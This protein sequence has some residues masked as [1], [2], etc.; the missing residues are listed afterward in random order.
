MTSRETIGSVLYRRM[1]A[2]GP[3]AAARNAALT[4]SAVTSRSSST[5]RSDSE[6]SST[7]TRSA[8]PSSRP[9]MPSITSPI[10]FAAPV[11]VGMMFTATARARCRPVMSACGEAR[12]GVRL[13]RV[14]GLAQLHDAVPV[15]LD[16]DGAALHEAALDA[17]SFVPVVGHDVSYL[18]ITTQRWR[19]TPSMRAPTRR[20]QGP[21]ARRH[22][23]FRP[24]PG[25]P[26]P[27]S[28]PEHDAERPS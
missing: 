9:A 6:P 23:D 21:I 1:P 20:G 5:A 4:S 11:L 15:M 17:R 7:G 14:S 24:W 3:R 10:D 16:P 19:A 18:L 12:L 26:R 25:C 13:D 22:E 8:S 2:S 27:T 28:E